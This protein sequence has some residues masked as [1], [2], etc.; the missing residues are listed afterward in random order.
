MKYLKIT[1]FLLVLLLICY[2]ALPLTSAKSEGPKSSTKT[3][4]K[5]NQ[6]FSAKSMVVLSQDDKNYRQD[7]NKILKR[8]DQ[9][10]L[11]T[12]VIAEQVRLTGALSLPT[13]AG[14]FDLELAPYDMRAANYRAEVSLDGGVVSELE[15]GSVRTYKG[16]V[17]GM[18]GA[19]V[20]FTIDESTLEGLIITPAQQFFIE[21]ARRYSASASRE[22]FLVYKASDVVETS[23]GECGVTLAE[24]VGKEAGRVETETLTASSAGGVV[25]EAVFSPPRLVDLATEADFEYFTAFGSS[26]TAANNEILS[27]MNQVEGIYNTQ[28]GLRFNVVFQNVWATAGDP[29]SSTAASTVL[30]EFTNFW[31]A[32]RGSVSR[33]L[34]HMWTGK[35]FDGNTI[36]IAWRPGLD[37]PFIPAGSGYG[38]SQRLAPA[39]E[40]FILSAH[41]IGHNFNATHVSTQPGCANTIMGT[42]LSSSTTMMFCP[43]SVNEIDLHAN[44]K[45]ACLS[46]VLTPGCTY[47]LSSTGQSF[48]TAGGT[49]NVGVTT[50]G[51]N[52]SW[53]ATSTV[54]WITINSGSSGI[55]SGNVN[56]TVSPSTGGYARS[57]VLRIAEQNFTVNQAGDGSCAITPISFGQTINGSLSPS[58]CRSSQAINSFADQYTF[59]G[60]AGRQIRIDMSS[61]GSP[62]VDTYLYLIGPVNV[63]GGTVLTENDDIVLGSNTN[64]R[65]PVN[66]F[67]TLPATGAYI[68]ESSSFDANETGPYSITLSDNSALNSVSFSSATFT[69][70]EGVDAN[71]LGIEGIGMRTI[72]VTRGGSDLSGAATVDYATSEG[73]G[74]ERRDYTKARGTLRFAPGDTSESFVIFVTDDVFKPGDMAR[75]RND[76]N[77]FIII[78]NAAETINLTLS[79]PVG[80][81]LGATATAVLTINNDD[82]TTGANPVRPATFNS[83][84]FVRQHYHDFLGR[85]PDL[86]GLNFWSNNI[87]SCGADQQCRALR[88]RDTSAAFFLSIEFQETGFLVHRASKAAF[89]DINPPAVPAPVRLN[90]FLSDTKRIGEGVVVG[91]GNWT[92]QLEN[93]KV[94]YFDEFVIR[95]QFIAIYPLTMTPQSFVDTLNSRSGGV[96]SPAEVSGLVSLLQ[97]GQRTRGQILRAV[98]EAPTMVQRETSRAFVLMQYFGYLRRNPDDLQ[99]TNF[100]GFNFWLNKLV[101]QAGGDYRAAQMIEAFIESIEYMERFGP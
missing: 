39:P 7:V 82:A 80:A 59:S 73:S 12:Q 81:T 33:D 30:D 5:N 26:A 89:G 101:N 31:N 11:D 16:T 98:A 18:A 75:S 78:E 96:L 38:I 49:A 92:T 95:P 43:T 2:G 83:R 32:N 48:A 56:Y 85:E 50:V 28:F 72:T 46:Q 47:T 90:E 54:P 42:T 52:C 57:G 69:V 74:D 61:T 84:F 94:A 45:A 29:Y 3:R 86:A 1:I 91:V 68:I 36:G 15:P 53:A 55:N 79:N 17:V 21:P 77:Q 8:Y 13:S 76:F 58:D 35:D 27:I 93:N 70:T 25:P 24:K 37:C 62:V 14:R 66:G 99:D 19:Q 67:F 4:T 65:I 51:S 97:S 9:L 71:G 64:S 44:A 100:N 41:E 60:V 10:E 6:A 40:K 22:D 88:R 34:A 20:R 63:P 23:F 87:E